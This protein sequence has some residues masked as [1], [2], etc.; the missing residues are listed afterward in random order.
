MSC[1]VRGSPWDRL[2]NELKKIIERLRELLRGP[3]LRNADRQVLSRAITLAEHPQV[4]RLVTPQHVSELREIASRSALRFEHR[5]DINAL[6]NEF[7]SMLRKR[8]A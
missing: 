6:A 4:D 5:A 1:S 7:V 3:W 8:A 2:L